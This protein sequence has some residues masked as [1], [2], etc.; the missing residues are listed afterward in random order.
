M[1]VTAQVLILFLL[2]STF[3]GLSPALAAP[4]GLPA[5]GQLGPQV[6]GR[7]GAQVQATACVE[8]NPSL[9]AASKGLVSDPT[10]RQA[11]AAQLH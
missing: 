10:T 1:R 8:A 6:R 2:L 7:L 11:A 5:S 3:G 9:P 4:P